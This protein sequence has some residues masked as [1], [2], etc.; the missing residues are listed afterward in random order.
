MQRTKKRVGRSIWKGNMKKLILFSFLMAIPCYVH[1][2]NFAEIRGMSRSIARDTIPTNGQPRISEV[3]VSSF[4]NVAVQEAAM[5][6]WC[7]TNTTSY[8]VISGKVLYSYNPDMV[9]IQRLTLDGAMIPATSIT[10]LDKNSQGNWQASMSTASPTVYYS[11][12]GTIGFDT[13]LSTAYNHTLS[14]TYI[15]V[16]NQLVNDSNVPFNGVSRYVPFHMAICYYTAALIC[17]ADNRPSEGDKYYKMYTDRIQNM[18]STIRL[19][20]DYY[21]TFGA[22]PVQ[23]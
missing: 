22:S 16:P 1:A 18:S 4:V 11:D 20:P 7:M 8:P 14:I 6:T 12:N 21:P 9:A 17:Y 15:Q 10:V 2:L 13:I 19:S 5:Y 3:M 23:R